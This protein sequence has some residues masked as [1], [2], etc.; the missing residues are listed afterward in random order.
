MH[1]DC[2]CAGSQNATEAVLRIF[3]SCFGKSTILNFAQ[4][5]RL[6]LC[7]TPTLYHRYHP[8]SALTFACDIP[9]PL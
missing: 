9:K 3:R 6:I 2:I 5:T 1:A 4:L 7:L 8:L